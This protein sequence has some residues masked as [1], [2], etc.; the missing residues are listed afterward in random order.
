M[1]KMC[2]VLLVLALGMSVCPSCCHVVT[3][4]TTGVLDPLILLDFMLHALMP[5]VA[6]EVISHV[7]LVAIGL[8]KPYRM[9]REREIPFCMVAKRLL[10]F[11]VPTQQEKPLLMSMY[12]S[13]CFCTVTGFYDTAFS[14]SAL[15]V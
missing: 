12:V 2:I 1:A 14:Y 7:L 6:L 5:S 11:L 4:Q 15:L 10:I 9:R 3:P 13:M 8:R